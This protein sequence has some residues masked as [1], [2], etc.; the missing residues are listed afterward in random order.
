MPQVCPPPAPMRPFAVLTPAMHLPATQ[1]GAL[2]PHGA[3]HAPQLAG[4]DD[5][6]THFP[7]QTTLPIAQQT[8]FVH[9]SFPAHAMPHPPQLFGS[10]RTST[11]LAPHFDRPIG[12]DIA[13]TPNEQTSPA[14]HVFPHAPQF[15]ASPNGSTHTPAQTVHPPG[16]G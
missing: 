6:S 4:S 3:P 15:L 5:V 11:Q 13:Q 14:P 9:T 10:T 2:T 8:P 1:N 7:E 12:H 16:H